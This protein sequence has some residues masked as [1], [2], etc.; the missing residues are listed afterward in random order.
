MSYLV[1]QTGATGD[2]QNLVLDKLERGRPRNQERMN[3]AGE[4][5]DAAQWQHRQQLR[6]L[7]L[8]QIVVDFEPLFPFWLVCH[9]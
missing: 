9:R 6:N 3:L 4:D 1:D 2:T 7:D 5:H 8:A